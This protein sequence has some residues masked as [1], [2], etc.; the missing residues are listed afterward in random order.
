MSIAK[1]RLIETPPH[2]GFTSQPTTARYSEE[3]SEEAMNVPTKHYKVDGKT[4]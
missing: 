3:I 2:I 1:G 4:R